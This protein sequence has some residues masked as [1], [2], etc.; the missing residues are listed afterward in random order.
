MHK[1]LIVVSVD[2]MVYE[3]LEKLRNMPNVG[4]L[5]GNGSL[6]KH[7]TTIYPSLTHPVHASLMSG[8]PAG[9][10]GIWNNE[11]FLPGRERLPWNNRMDQMRCDTLFHAAKRCGLTTAACRWPMTAGGFAQID[12]LVPEVMDD[13][14]EAEPDLEKL[15]RRVCTP[16]L[17]ED[18]IRPHLNILE[19][20]EKHPAYE[21]FSM[22]CAAAI[23]QRHKPDLLLT[24]PGMVDHCRHQ[25]GL[26]SPQVEDALRMTDEWIGWLMQAVEDAGIRDETSF[27]IVSDHGHLE[28]A[29]EVAVNALFARIGLLSRNEDGSLGEWKAFCHSAGHSGQVY[30]R[31]RSCLAQVEAQLR[32]MAE[33][34]VYGF[35]QVLT[36]SQARERYGL[37]GDFAFVIESDGCSVFSTDW[38]EPAIR[39]LP[40][41]EG[42]HHHSDHGHMPERGP[43]PPMIVCGPA[44]R[45]GVDI[46]R[47]D[48]LDEAP[49]FAAALGIELPQ[50]QGRA[51]EELLA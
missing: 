2:A 22:R 1:R 18:V 29:R 50:A 27:C 42:G 13:E 5:I 21:V 31:D 6:V 20:S 26:Y 15:Y 36:R 49:T 34:G 9:K 12:W 37:D 19:S 38:R 16:E 47:G 8:N 45:S 17:F 43:Q 32:R 40:E 51:I 30:V 44:F 46:D 48:L 39:V 33:E 24:H 25:S 14:V 23:I 28:Y 3:D 41:V 4:R 7:M 10:T 11:V 35:T